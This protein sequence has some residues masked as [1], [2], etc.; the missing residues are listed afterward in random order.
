MNFV[1][2]F[3]ATQ[4]RDRVFD[5]RLTNVNLLETTLERGIFLDMLVV[6]AQGGGANAAQ[7]TTSQRR[8]QHVRRVDRAF[9]RARANECVQLVDEEHD[10][11]LRVLDLFQ[12]CFQTIFK[13]AAILRARKHRAQ[14]KCD[15][16]LVT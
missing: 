13:L 8:L 12:N 9:S 14:I 16:S 7:L 11:T 5:S 15:E 1:A 2:L 4:D 6:F 3:Q 10:M